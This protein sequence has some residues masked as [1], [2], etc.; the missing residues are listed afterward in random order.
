MCGVGTR[1]DLRE[2]QVVFLLNPNGLDWMLQFIDLPQ[3]LKSQFDF[4]G[5]AL[6]L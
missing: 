6:P 3:F 2:K 4:L 1:T 5:V